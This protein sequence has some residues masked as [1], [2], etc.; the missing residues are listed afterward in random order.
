MY[1]D[2]PT[3][4]IDLP[5]RPVVTSRTSAINWNSRI[6]GQTHD[7]A[8]LIF[9]IH[10]K[11]YLLSRP[12]SSVQG[13]VL[14]NCHL[15]ECCT[16]SCLSY[17]TH[18]VYARPILWHRLTVSHILSSDLEKITLCRQI[19]ASSHRWQPATNGT[20]WSQQRSNFTTR[21]GQ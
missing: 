19:L 6:T 10:H 16:P 7:I 11:T 21:I 15:L 4:S 1:L 3:I 17:F 5:R 9:N 20:L 8:R 13:K 18:A 14:L 2:Y 12:S